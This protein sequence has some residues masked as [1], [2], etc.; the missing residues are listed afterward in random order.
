MNKKDN[1]ESLTKGVLIFTRL[2]KS[3]LFLFLAIFLS[4]PVKAQNCPIIDT[5]VVINDS[6]YGAAQAS[7]EL[8]M[9]DPL[10]SYSYNWNNGSTGPELF[11]IT[12]GTYTVQII[13]NN[14]PTC[15]QDTMFTI[16]QPQ[17]PL[18]SVVNLNQHVSCYGDS[19]GA[20]Y[21]NVIGGTLPYTY[22]WS[23]GQTTQQATGLWG[24]PAG[25]GL[26]FVHNVTITDDW[27]CV[28][29]DGIGIINMHE[30]IDGS[31]DI[32]QNVSCFDAC[33]GIVELSTSG[34]VLQHRYFWDNGQTYL[35]SGPDT[36]LNLCYGG[37][38]VIIEDAEGC[39]KTVPFIISQ[40]DE[41]FAQAIQVQPVQCYGF[42]DGISSAS[43]TGG[44]TPYAFT[45]DSIN[46]PSGP[47]I[48]S[49]TP[50]I[51]TI[52]VTDANGCMASD[53]VVI[54]EPT[55]L[56][57]IIV[58]TMTIYSY[59]AGTNSGQLCAVASGGTPN[60]NYVWNDALVQTTTC[61]FNIPARSADYTVIV[62]DERNCIDSASFKLDSIT[63]SM[64]PDSVRITVNHVS[65]FNLYD[66][67]ISVSN[68]V[69][70]VGPY[71][72][73]WVGPITPPS[74]TPYVGMGANISSLYNG[75]YALVIEDLNGCDIVIDVNVLEPDEL[76]YTTYNVISET[77]YGAGDGQIWVNVIGGTGNYYY[78]NSEV[79]TFP[80]P[81]VNQDILINDSLILN[82]SEGLHSIYVTDDNNCEG[83]VVWGGTWQEQVDSGVVVTVTGVLT[84]E[85]SCFNTN[86]GQAWVQWPG[87]NPLFNYTWET[88]SP[89]PVIL[90]TGDSTSILLPGN[91][92][93]VAH[94]AN[95]ASFGQN[96]VGCDSVVPFTISSPAVLVS[97]YVVADENCFGTNDGSITLN[98]SS[99]A[100]GTPTVV[101]DTT[102][103]IPIGSPLLTALNVFPLEPGVYTATITD[104]NGCQITEYYTVNEALPMTATISFIPPS[105]NGDSDGSATINPNG[106]TGPWNI[107]WSPSG[108][109]GLVTNPIGAG[110]YTANAVDGNGC[111]ASFS[112][113]V[114]EPD[115]II[116][117]V[118]SSVFYN[119]D[120]NGMP[121]NISC[122]Y[123]ADGE[124]TATNGGGVPPYIYS[125]IPM[126]AGLSGQLATGL[127]AGWNKVIVTDA[128]GC[129]QTDST[130][131]YEPDYLN[132]NIIESYYSTSSDGTTNEIECYDWNNGWIE[133]ETFGGVPNLGYQ[134]EW[135]DDNTGQI[136]SLD[137][138]AANLSANT[139]YTV[140]V[141]DANGCVSD[142][143]SSVLDHPAEFVA[144]VVR[145][146][147]GGPTHADFWV[148]FVDNTTSIDPYNF[149]WNW[150]DGT[151]TSFLAGTPSMD[152][153]FVEE[154]I[155][156]N[157][158]Y[159]IL[160]NEATGCTAVD[161][162]VID[163][164][165]IPE[166]DNVFTPNGDNINE[167]FSFGEYGMS[168]IDVS[169][170]NRW[171]QLVNSWNGM[172]KSW[173]GK[174][175]DGDN[176][177]EGVYFYVLVAEGEDG[178]YY[179][180]KGSITLL[181]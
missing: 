11:F 92:N 155:G 109:S 148:N 62:M 134:Y 84:V 165:G 130:Y 80:I 124:A 168:R 86:D 159:V 68:V 180:Y 85:P 151:T 108:G 69:G 181:R 135:V 95:T 42:D 73:D 105:C 101:W 153:E 121:Y 127:S 18:S 82:L 122:K 142:T 23:N 175:I 154:N 137:A 43:A 119:E 129:T 94:Y 66:G 143:T 113:T 4:M 83:A 45:W 114:T 25:Q 78:D 149:N 49:L 116:A 152:L 150:P 38:S 48:D 6:C 70:G 120:D 160:L 21:V 22:L 30:A 71:T 2:Y 147:Y 140:T 74:V 128:N 29:T 13:D 19:T 91:Y 110:L 104:A 162:F 161:S 103:S 10:G 136:V 170:Y 87:A 123:S 16:T 158:V 131:L 166:I 102:T 112:V 146:N 111:I 5:A 93:L 118:E 77:C 51:H 178:H 106:G 36:T 76:K 37:H 163:V 15:I 133:S 157:N 126:P 75:N 81:A 28:L 139:S 32:I 65:C 8:F 57:V 100:S 20:A 97:N 88:V 167:E 99:S 173:D 54:T 59:C 26:P 174:G 156:Q 132:P 63:N 98:P 141:I 40:P 60:Y 3:V 144:D 27:G 164:Q 17:D 125:W 39:R 46:G 138:L 61:A 96:Y 53:T 115:D 7:I 90:D 50:G 55:Q 67:A 177:P 72:Y 64:D 172:N 145:T 12:A 169:I 33:D 52:Y 56:D 44:T 107:T 47:N 24:D 89:T 58:D 9:L 35:G 171:G 14:N 1:K 31:I 34:G 179:D 176:V 117:G 41:L 79:G